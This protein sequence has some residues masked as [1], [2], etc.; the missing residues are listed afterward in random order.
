MGIVWG[1]GDWK[2]NSRGLEECLYRVQRLEKNFKEKKRV[3][4]EFQICSVL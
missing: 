3:R 2:G 1:G 4:K